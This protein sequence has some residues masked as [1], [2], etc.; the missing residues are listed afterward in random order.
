MIR[1]RTLR[2]LAVATIAAALAS[3][4]TYAGDYPTRPV[5][6]IVGFAAGSSVDL[7]A[8]LLAQRFTERLGQPFIVENRGGAGGNLA[9]EAVARGSKD[10]HTL[11]LATNGIANASAMGA[12]YDPVK[13]FAPITVIATGPQMLV[14]HPSLKVDNLAQL[15]ALAKQQPDQITYGGGTG[16]TMTGLAGVLLNSMA[17]IKLRH[18]PYPGSAPALVDLL[19]G[20]I[21]LLFAPALAVKSHV[22]K[23]QVKAIATTAA[24]RAGVA[25][26]VPTMAE[27]GVPGYEL[28]LW[29]GLVG[30]AGM[31]REAIDVLS[32]VADEALKSSDIIE[33]LRAQGI[34]PVGGTPEEFARFIE[35]EAEKMARMAKLGGITK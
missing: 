28:S 4:S 8:R 27:A 13:D 16:F 20:R 26:D 31:P 9:A 17:D 21:D 15:I 35:R 30:P 12:S 32:R 25:P 24:A 14:A 2:N 11:L 3:T 33:P 5:R 1:V 34:D 6:I 18:I 22:E 19:A 29:Y 23:R 7:P 10:G